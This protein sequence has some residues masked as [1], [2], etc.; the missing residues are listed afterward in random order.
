MAMFAALTAIFSQLV[1]PLPFTPI[2]I[3]LATLAVLLCGML[4]S[5][6][7]AVISMTVFALVGAVGVPVFAGFR[8]GLA[9]LVGPTGGYILGYIAMAWVVSLIRAKFSS[10]AWVLVAGAILGTIALYT[11]GTVWFLVLTGKS[12]IVALTSCVL[13]FLIGDAIKIAVALLITGRVKKLTKG[14]FYA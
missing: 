14:Y 5:P 7:S 2:M 1:I 11:L 8:G 4:L 12:L 10:K 6:L 9:V 13:P 3:S